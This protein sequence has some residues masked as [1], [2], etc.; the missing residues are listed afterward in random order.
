MLEDAVQQALEPLLPLA[1]GARLSIVETPALTAID[2]DSGSA[3]GGA[4]G[5]GALRLNLEAVTEIARQLRLRGIGGLVVI[6]FLRMRDPRHQAEVLA[7][8]RD[9]LAADPEVGQVL[10][11]SP[12]GLVELVRRRRGPSLAERLLEPAAPVLRPAAAAALALRR[13][14]AEQAAVQGRPLRLACPPEVAR[15][16][17]PDRLA[18]AGVNAAV[19][20]DPSVPRHAPAI[21][22]A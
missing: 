22:P 12:L 7:A 1:S 17:P 5:T 4:A 3:R 10:P 6:D 11:F 21:A 13:L 2:L 8:L 19:T 20:A 9:T 18:A 16:L 15:L 14:R